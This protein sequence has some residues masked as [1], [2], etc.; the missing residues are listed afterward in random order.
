MYFKKTPT[1]DQPVLQNCIYTAYY[2]FG[3]NL[4]VKKFFICLIVKKKNKIFFIIHQET[5]IAV[6]ALTMTSEREE[7]IDFVAPYFEQSGILIGKKKNRK[8]Y[9]TEIFFF[10]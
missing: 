9:M 2:K 3:S 6:A 7:V 8:K 1:I 5:D 4:D 10:I